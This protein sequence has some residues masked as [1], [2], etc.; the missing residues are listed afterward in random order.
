MRELSVVDLDSWKRIPD[1]YTLGDGF[2]I[3]RPVQG[4]NYYH[5]IDSAL[6]EIGF[7]DMSEVITGCLSGMQVHAEVI[8]RQGVQDF[9][10]GTSFATL[11]DFL[12]DAVCNLPIDVP[13]LLKEKRVSIGGEMPNVQLVSRRVLDGWQISAPLMEASLSRE[14]RL[15]AR[16]SLADV[17]VDTAATAARKARTRRQWQ[18]TI[19][20]GYAPDSSNIES[21]VERAQ[22]VLRNNPISCTLGPACVAFASGAES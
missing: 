1:N 10:R 4:L 2:V 6:A 17:A 18:P 19:N 13:G 11:D 16:A 21:M 9:L 20:L 7:E 22:Q 15:L 3:F 5:H 12:N 8:S 14:E